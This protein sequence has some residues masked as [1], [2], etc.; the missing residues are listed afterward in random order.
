MKNLKIKHRLIFAFSI[1]LTFILIISSVAIIKL[2]TVNVSSTILTEQLLKKERLTQTWL[3]KTKEN[4]IRA[5][6]M[7]RST[8]PEIAKYFKSD[9]DT[10]TK[11]INEVQKNLELLITNEK[12]KELFSEVSKKRSAYIE[13]R[14]SIL[15][16]KEKRENKVN[17]QIDSLMIPALNEYIQ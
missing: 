10:T 14:K 1:I 6:S 11:S 5:I 12:E 9:V 13:K 4:S 3:S 8:D 2:N 17:E 16:I 7:V 15:L